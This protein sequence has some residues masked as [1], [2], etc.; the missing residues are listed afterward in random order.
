MASDSS[1]SRWL[2]LTTTDMGFPLHRSRFGGNGRHADDPVAGM[3]PAFLGVGGLPPPAARPHVFAGADGARAG[4]AADRGIALVVQRVVGNIE[5]ADE[6]PDEFL[7][8][9]G[10][11]VV[12][13]QPEHRVLLGLG[14]LAAGG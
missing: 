11:L 2:R 13:V 4:L 5:S 10:Q 3:Q 14:Q 1:Q 12:L 7:Y 9:G 6:V 8:P